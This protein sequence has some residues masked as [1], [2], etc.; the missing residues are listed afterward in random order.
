MCS[1]VDVLKA[2]LTPLIAAI[3]AYIAWQQWSTNRNKLRHELFERR[4]EIYASAYNVLFSVSVQ[5]HASGEHLAAFRQT[6]YKSDFLLDES[7][8]AL[9]SEIDDKY[10]E[11]RILTNELAALN[12]EDQRK[13]NL[14]KQRQIKDWMEKQKDDLKSRFARYLKVNA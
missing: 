6:L 13:E 7:L 9:L 5:G 10:D 8:S 12:N 1:W 11:L 3:A 2:L 14:R 4:F